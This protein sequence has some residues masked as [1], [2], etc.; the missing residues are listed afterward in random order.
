MSI[1]DYTTTDLVPTFVFGNQQDIITQLVNNLITESTDVSNSNFA[2]ANAASTQTI[3]SVIQYDPN[4]GDAD[5]NT[6]SNSNEKRIATRRWCKNA[7]ITNVMDPHI[8]AADYTFAGA[9]VHSADLRV[10][11]DPT[12]A[13]SVTR[14][15]WVESQDT[16]AIATANNTIRGNNNTWTGTN[17]FNTSLPTSTVT[18][19]SNT[20]LITKVF[21]DSTYVKTTG[22]ETIAGAKTFSTAPV[23]SGASITSATIPDGALA[24]TFVKPSTA[25]VLTGT[26]FTGIPDGALSSTFVKPST[27]PVLTGTNFTGIPDGALSST[28]VKTSGDETIAGI[29]TFSSAPVLS[30]ASITSATIA[31]ASLASTFVKPS[32]SPILDGTNFTGI[33]DGALSSTFVKPS[34]APTLTGT[35]F[36]GIPQSGVT[37]L[38]SDLSGKQ[39]TIGGSSDLSFRDL[40]ASGTIALPSASISDAMLAS[41]FV[42]TSTD[43][44][45]AGIKTFSSAPVLSGASITSSTIPTSAINANLCT[46]DTT[47]T[48]SAV[49]TFSAN[50]KCNSI[51]EDLNAVT[52]NSSNNYTANYNTSSIAYLST[53]PSAN[54]TLALHNSGASTTKTSVFTLI[55]ANSNLCY[56]T[57][58]NIYS[59]AGSTSISCTTVW[60]NGTPSI[61][62][63]TVSVLT[64]SVMKAL[65]SN[66][67]LCS[68]ANYY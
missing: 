25:P 51:C 63:A 24:S 49:K 35:N 53:A 43:Q 64:I 2:L 44:T 46:T 16:A 23:L 5:D 62:S 61:S 30:G 22:T 31:D 12:L 3:T 45:I 41:T 55:Y 59:D 37:N 54:F 50:M 26:N 57:T 42:K 4:D 17:A 29:K 33:P 56:P 38:T 20:Q 66:Y 1:P 48:I 34:T 15:S 36:T 10:Q 8:Q 58:L 18:P 7:Y 68:V 47:Q 11:N 6:T 28:F 65:S 60:L 27:A 13:N 52:T 32:T 21:A 19:S 40:T 39:A 9:H 14:R 67:A